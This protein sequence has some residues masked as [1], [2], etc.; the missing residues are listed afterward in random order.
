MSKE[1]EIAGQ[2]C[3][4]IHDMAGKGYLKMEDLLVMTDVCIEACKRAK[5]EAMED[6]LK[7]CIE[8]RG[9]QDGTDA[10]LQ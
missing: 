10:G 6:I 9:F 3:D 8:M 4:M 1:E 5:T 7:A 2:L